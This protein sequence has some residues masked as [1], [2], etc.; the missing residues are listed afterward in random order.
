M[1][2]R[3]ACRLFLE[4]MRVDAGAS[5]L[6]L[7]AYQRDLAGFGA[8]VG[9]EQDITGITSVEVTRFIENLSSQGMK[10]TTIAR[11]MSCLRRLFVFCRRELGLLRDP[12]EEIPTPKRPAQLPKDLTQEETQKLLSESERGL[13]YH[14]PQKDVF[15]A[16][17][18]AMIYLLYATGT[19][20][21]ELISLRMTDLDLVEGF[22]RVQGKRGKQRI[23]PFPP[24]AGEKVSAYLSVREKLEPVTEHVFLSGSGGGLTRQAFWKIIKDLARQAGIHKNVSPHVLRHSFATHLLNSGMGLRTLQV[25]LGHADVTTTQI[26]THLSDEQMKEVHRKHHPRGGGAGGSKS[27]HEGD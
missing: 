22:L 8:F 6:T 26:Y 1:D 27:G 20:V 24:V 21:S 15:H 25:L 13:P 17:D 11:K 14:S 10:A 18:R 3:N 9:L 4:A 5:A 16:R 12:M 19:R 2:L 23:A 7:D